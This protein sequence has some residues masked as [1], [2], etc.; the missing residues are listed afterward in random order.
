MFIS[1]FLIN[2]TREGE[3][4]SK[5]THKKTQSIGEQRIN[6][7]FPTGSIWQPQKLLAYKMSY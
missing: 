1:S 2:V 6:N 3:Q 5:K 7:G 4:K